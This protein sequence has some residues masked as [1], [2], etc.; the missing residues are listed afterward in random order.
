MSYHDVDW[1]NLDYP[2]EIGHHLSAEEIEELDREIAAQSPAPVRPRP[3]VDFAALME[4]W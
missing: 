1:A 2:G 3:A 4:R